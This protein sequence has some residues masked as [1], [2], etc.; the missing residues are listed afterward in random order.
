MTNRK[1]AKYAV[2][3][4]GE[5]GLRT[6]L[7]NWRTC[8]PDDMGIEPHFIEVTFWEDGGFLESLP[9]PKSL[10][11]MLRGRIQ[12]S[13]GLKKGPFDATI[14]AVHSALA[15]RPRYVE[16]NA[17]YAVFDV[18]PRQMHEFGPFYGKRPSRLPLVESYKHKARSRFYRNCRQL[19]PWSS[20]AASSVIADYGADPRKVRPMPP[21]VDLQKWIGGDLSLKNDK[22]ICDILF[23]G[24][25][26]ERK[27]GLFLLDWAKNTCLT[28]WRLHIVTTSPVDA[29]D[30]KRV[31]I[32]H[33]LKPNDPQLIAL[34]KNADLFALPT[35]ADCYSIA[36]IE[37]LAS[38]LPVILGR[39]GGAGEVVTDGATGYTV[40]PGNAGDLEMR[41]DELVANRSLRLT[42]GEEARYEAERRFD[43]RN[44]LKQLLGLVRETL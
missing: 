27:G 21:G 15:D 10:I 8:F 43:A 31:C 18:T 42:M 13:R 40:E 3:M 23:V 20:W 44:N 22:E 9:A 17:C 19:F 28:N 34:Y 7:E 38:G 36:G 32:Y 41:M 39:S 26:F 5:L 4:S 24:G 35:L 16:Q 30:D 29:G 14:V 12:I 6:Q 33:G 37:A 11:S 25:Q 2:I 1:R